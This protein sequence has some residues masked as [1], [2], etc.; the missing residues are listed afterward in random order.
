MMYRL[1]ACKMQRKAPTLSPDC[2]VG[3]QLVNVTST[4]WAQTLK[5]ELVLAIKR[6]NV[7]SAPIQRKKKKVNSHILTI[8]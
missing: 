6:V 8:I 4:L 3:V 5:L 2:K 7:S 1:F